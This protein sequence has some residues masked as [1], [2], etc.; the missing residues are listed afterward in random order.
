[1]KKIVPALTLLILLAACNLTENRES[2][3]QELIDQPTTTQTDSN[4]DNTTPNDTEDLPI[5]SEEGLNDDDSNRGITVFTGNNNIIITQ[6]EES[7]NLEKTPLTLEE[8]DTWNLG[9]AYKTL[10]NDINA[11]ST[12]IDREH[13][14]FTAYDLNIPERTELYCYILSN[15]DELDDMVTTQNYENNQG[16]IHTYDIYNDTSV[17]NDM[18]F[19]DTVYMIIDY[20][21]YKRELEV[22][23]Y[24]LKQD[25]IDTYNENGE[26]YFIN[27]YGD[28][29][30]SKVTTGISYETLWSI[31]SSNSVEYNREKMISTLK[32]IYSTIYLGIDLK[33]ALFNEGISELEFYTY[34]K[35]EDTPLLSDELIFE[36]PE[37]FII[38]NSYQ[39][40][41]G[42]DSPYLTFRGINTH[43]EF[44]ELKNDIVSTLNENGGAS[45]I[46][47]FERF[48][49]LPEVENNFYSD[50]N[51]L[52]D[53]LD[54]VDKASS[55]ALENFYTGIPNTENHIYIINSSNTELLEMAS[56][57]DD[58]K[59]RRIEF[60]DIDL[61]FTQKYF[62]YINSY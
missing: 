55:I 44:I 51:I 57:I 18:D 36:K 38:I 62:D 31:R 8:I 12:A 59:Y 58:F 21:H 49:I 32:V 30:L 4:K 60:S 7:N 2:D 33:T 43:A 23:S 17:L 15:E 3:L 19:S 1:M 35:W 16:N 40:I 48:N 13:P 26:E 47:E 34:M 25:C 24:E 37:S 11:H 5:E 61:T 54:I 27:R 29:F 53:Y 14:N 20:R 52:Y 46:R 28:S 42:M 41:K 6:L 39:S 10:D 56:I 22:D 45:R 9:I 50:L